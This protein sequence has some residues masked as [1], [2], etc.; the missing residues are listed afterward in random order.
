M[1]GCGCLE[2]IETLRL[3]PLSF[4]PSLPPVGPEPEHPSGGQ[5]AGHAGEEAGAARR[6]QPRGAA[7]L[8]QR[9]VVG[10]P[11][12]PHHPAGHPG[13]L[14]QDHQRAAHGHARQ[15][16]QG[17]RQLQPGE[18]DND[19]HV[20]DTPVIIMSVRSGQGLHLTSQFGKRNGLTGCGRD[21]CHFV[22]GG[23]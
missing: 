19:R 8:H 22:C 20:C 2:R 11:R 12:R 18:R 9:R 6:E 17:P 13:E 10:H 14:H 4:S 3:F 16:A 7:R 23:D 21:Q 1:W 15:P 5:V